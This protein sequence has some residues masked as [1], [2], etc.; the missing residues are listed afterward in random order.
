MQ[1]KELALALRAALSSTDAGFRKAKLPVEITYLLVN[2]KIC[3]VL[4][5]LLGFKTSK[6]LPFSLNLWCNHVV[7]GLSGG[8]GVPCLFQFPSGLHNFD[9]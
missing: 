5:I 4:D 6:T 8:S 9:P 1:N 3:N 2:C 7:F